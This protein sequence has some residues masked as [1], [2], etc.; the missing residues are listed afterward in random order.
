MKETEG[1]RDRERR[2]EELKSLGGNPISQ[3]LLPVR[4]E[5]RTE[6]KVTTSRTRTH[7]DPR[8]ELAG[9]GFR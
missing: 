3:S 2:R 1:Q 8:V 7:I 6:G 4:I 9:K 5:P